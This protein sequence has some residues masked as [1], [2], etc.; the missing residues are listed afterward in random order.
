MWDQG[1]PGVRPGAFLPGQPVFLRS[2]REDHG[3]NG[4]GLNGYAWVLG[5]ELPGLTGACFAL[6]SKANGQGGDGAPPR[7][8]GPAVVDGRTWVLGADGCGA[9]GCG[10]VESP[11]TGPGLLALGP[12]ISL[13]APAL[14][15][16]ALRAPALRAPAFQAPAFQ[17]PAFQDP[18]FQ[19]PDSYAREYRLRP[20]VQ[21]GRWSAAGRRHSWLAAGLACGGRCADGGVVTWRGCLGMGGLLAPEGWPAFRADGRC[22]RARP[23]FAVKLRGNRRCR[24]VTTRRGMPIA[25]RML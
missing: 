7:G 24:S 19:D 4:Y 18:A 8:R 12:L 15:A 14:R 22:V 21:P 9:D 20:R 1:G 13:R 10:N 5:P 2:R 17:A 25:G 6:V 3:L 23:S 11:S 16:P